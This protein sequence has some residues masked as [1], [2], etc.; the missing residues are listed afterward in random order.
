M[1]LIGTV[2]AIVLTWLMGHVLV[3]WLR[4]NDARRAGDRALDFFLSM[5]VGLCLSSFGFFAARLL[6]WTSLPAVL[7]FDLLVLAAVALLRWCLPSARSE[8]AGS[9]RPVESEP[10]V[11]CRLLQ[12]ALGVSAVA[13][14][15]L[16]STLY[17]LAELGFW[18]AFA[19]WNLKAK[20]FV[21]EGPAWQQVFSDL[22]SWSH[23]DY[24]LLLPLNVAR[25]WIY[26]GEADC[27]VSA[28]LSILFTM[29]IVGLLYAGVARVCGR[30]QGCLAALALLATSGF[31]RQGANQVAD[32]PVA[33]FLLAAFCTLS[34]S[35][36]TTSTS[37]STSSAEGHRPGRHLVLA[38]LLIG[39]AA[40]T[41]NEGALIALALLVGTFLVALRNGGMRRALSGA[42]ILLL[43]LAVPLVCLATLKLGFAGRSDLFVEPGSG[44]VLE[45]LVDG[46]RHWA[47]LAFG[48]GLIWDWV[49][50]TLLVV[51]LVFAVVSGPV[52]DKSR[53]PLIASV[54]ITVFLTVAGYYVV[55]V[56][57]PRDLQWHLSTAADRLMVHVWPS[58]LFLLFMASERR[59]PATAQTSAAGSP[60]LGS[61]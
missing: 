57:T 40:W 60:G 3:A 16:L 41:K 25:L 1:M 33:F 42:G 39:A 14:I 59:Q 23:T 51:L 19:I 58:A 26:A 36:P 49:G 18:D 47:I 8:L 46:S 11:T 29:L 15:V 21:C 50:G 48:G 20:F 37:T 56:L 9:D 61:P 2:V 7:V 12:L 24:P 53:R 45:R 55:F 13:A 28:G 30:V 43:G 22:I 38:G 44:T 10:V 35:F 32:L 6:D 54:A 5:G 52:R 17:T 27:L 4:G 34:F 31:V